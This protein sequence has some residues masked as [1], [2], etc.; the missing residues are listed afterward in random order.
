M[1]QT[2]VLGGID[3]LRFGGRN[4]TKLWYLHPDNRLET[5]DRSLST[6]YISIV[7]LLLIYFPSVRVQL[8]FDYYAFSFALYKTA[9]IKSTYC[10]IQLL[11]C[12]EYSIVKQL[13][14]VI[15]LI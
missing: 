11:K 10:Q 6:R 9:L 5:T 15:K 3:Q 13:T 14:I 4:V 12:N 7:F 1:L 2:Y 8:R